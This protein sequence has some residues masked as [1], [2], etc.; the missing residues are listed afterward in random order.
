MSHTVNLRDHVFSMSLLALVCSC[1]LAACSKTGEASGQQASIPEVISESSAPHGTSRLPPLHLPFV[2]EVLSN[3]LVVIVSEDHSSPIVEVKVGYRV[4]PANEQSGQVGFTHLIQGLMFTPTAHRAQEWHAAIAGHGGSEVTGTYGYD[5]ETYGE[6]VPTGALPLALWM[7]SDRMANLPDALTPQALDRTRK[8]VLLPRPRDSDRTTSDLF[9][10]IAAMAYPPDHPYSRLVDATDDVA[11]ATVAK[12]QSWLAEHHGAANSVLVIA[13]DI[14]P[15]KGVALAQEYFGSLPPGPPVRHRTSWPIKIEGHQQLLAGGPSDGL[16]LSKLWAG[17]G[18][19]SPDYPTVELLSELLQER[20]VARLF[21]TRIVDG[22]N[23]QVHTGI[24]S[25]VLSVDIVC[26]DPDRRGAVEAALEREIAQLM[27]EGPTQTELRQLT[28]QRYTQL[29][30]T[31]EDVPERAGQLMMGELASRQPDLAVRWFEAR[32]SATPAAIRDALVRWIGP[33]AGA[34]TVAANGAVEKDQSLMPVT[35]R[36][37]SAAARTGIRSASTASVSRS[38]P[39][40]YADDQDHLSLTAQPQKRVDFIEPPPIAETSPAPLPKPEHFKLRNGVPVTL[41]ERHSAPLLHVDWMMRNGFAA[42]QGSTPGLTMLALNMLSQGTEHLTPGALQAR[43]SEQGIYTT[44]E[45]TTDASAI[46]FSGLATDPDKL[47]ELMG[48][49]LRHP[50][51]TKA[52]FDLL[53]ASWQGRI[54]AEVQPVAL[55]QFLGE[56][57]IYGQGH[58][59]ALSPRGLGTYDTIRQVTVENLRA[60]QHKWIRPDNGELLVVG[61]I[62]RSQLEPIAERYFGDWRAPADPPASAPLPP[63]PPQ[64]PTGVALFDRPNAKRS[65][66]LG[67][68]STEPPTAGDMPASELFIDAFGRSPNARIN[69][70]PRRFQAYKTNSDLE[71]R[72]GGAVFSIQSEVDADQTVAFIQWLQAQ[73]LDAR[74]DRSFSDEEVAKVRAAREVAYLSMPSTTDFMALSYETIIA[75]GSPEEAWSNKLADNRSV[76][77]RQVRIA[78]ATLLDPSQTI[79][80]VIGDA[81]QLE[82]PLRERLGIP[83]KVFDIGNMD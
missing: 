2:R 59:Y 29:L 20:L 27:K 22:V 62:T 68:R 39:P 83:V 38:E 82:G 26:G 53:K 42:D 66:V 46:R 45:A 4:G 21:R 71:V 37:A 52:N 31:F 48:D 3:G 15:A 44:V 73:M 54:H 35:S 78:A 5:S 75:R 72:K 23:T 50:S 32:Q 81:R 36:T 24:V 13:G 16:V 40:V 55:A 7:E 25:T 57:L 76:T 43:E 9:D 74:G 10:R 56:S 79:W 14:D 61:D 80:V 11:K 47:F 69:D 51:F 8:E 70:P 18:M 77:T 63:L 12:A 6:L 67:V 58:P 33:E 17:P 30:R 41:I 34:I 60:Y 64:L 49:E 1:L 65:V 28:T 19:G